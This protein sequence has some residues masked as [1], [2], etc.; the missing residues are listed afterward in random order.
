[1]NLENLYSAFH[2][3]KLNPFSHKKSNNE[4]YI[5]KDSY[6]IENL[7]SSFPLYTGLT[8]ENQKYYER[9]TDDRAQII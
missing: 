8:P 9:K 3:K 1:M 2:T 4:N 5:F 6:I 7:I